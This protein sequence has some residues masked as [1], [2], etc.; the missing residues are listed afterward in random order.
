MFA[1]LFSI[2]MVLG[3]WISQQCWWWQ[4]ANGLVSL[5]VMQMVE[6]VNQSWPQIKKSDPWRNYLIFSNIFHSSPSSGVQYAV[7]TS[8]TT[9][10]ISSS[11]NVMCLLR[12]PS[13]SLRV[14]CGLEKERF[15]HFQLFSLCHSSH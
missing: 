2:P 3:T 15:S 14:S 5:G 1:F 13:L 11:T 6:R 12:F 9:I 7:R 4:Y 10:S 8:T